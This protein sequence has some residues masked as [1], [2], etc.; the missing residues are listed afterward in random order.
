M[1]HGA[2]PM[3]IADACRVHALLKRPNLMS[4]RR[5]SKYDN[6]ILEINLFLNNFELFSNANRW[7][8]WCLQPGQKFLCEIYIKERFFKL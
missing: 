2:A 4:F 8:R 5:D 6:L 1:S 3:R 7:S